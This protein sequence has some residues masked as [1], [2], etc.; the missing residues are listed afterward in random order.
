MFSSTRWTSTK[1]VRSELTAETS[2]SPKHGKIIFT[3][4]LLTKVPTCPKQ[5][6]NV[7]PLFWVV[8][9]FE[10]YEDDMAFRAFVIIFRT[11]GKKI[12]LYANDFYGCYGNF[13]WKVAFWKLLELCSKSLLSN[14][15]RIDNCI[16]KDTLQFYILRTWINMRA[17]SFKTSVNVTEA[18]IDEGAWKKMSCAKIHVC[19]WKTIAPK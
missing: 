1:F 9:T 18:R 12:H 7:T 11:N 10:W 4:V 16:L 17:K 6:R 14:T 2:A 13:F 8:L 15:K 3:K 5:K 19:T